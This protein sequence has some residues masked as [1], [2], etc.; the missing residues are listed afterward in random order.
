MTE[1]TK[2]QQEQIHNIY[3]GVPA[4]AEQI[5]H[6]IRAAGGDRNDCM[7]VVEMILVYIVSGLFEEVGDKINLEGFIR[8]CEESL[9]RIRSAMA[10]HR[11]KAMN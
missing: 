9:K 11:K 2:E 6:A 3:Q 4:V 7:L 1:L 10:E 8:S 5:I